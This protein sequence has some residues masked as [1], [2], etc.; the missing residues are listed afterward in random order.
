M[1]LGVA[2]CCPLVLG[3]V[4]A[5]RDL[6]FPTE[7]SPDEVEF[8]S[9]TF[10]GAFEGLHDIDGEAASR[11]VVGADPYMI[12]RFDSVPLLRSQ[13]A[14]FKLGAR[15]PNGETRQGTAQL[16]WSVERAPFAEAKSAAFPIRS[17]DRVHI[18][19]PALSSVWTGKLTGL[20]IDLPSEFRDC[21]VSVS[22]VKLLD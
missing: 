15:C 13:V 10:P 12:F 11:R 19:R 2:V 7:A 4:A 1:R 18:V 3:L 17:I 5:P 8:Y 21:E 9:A 20:R 14:T 16:F 22:D 6:R